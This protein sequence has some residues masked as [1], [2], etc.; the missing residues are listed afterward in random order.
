MVNSNNPLYSVY[1]WTNIQQCMLVVDNFHVKI[2]YTYT[3][4]FI[5]GQLT[6]THVCCIEYTWLFANAQ[7]Y[8]VL[9]ISNSKCIF[10]TFKQFDSTKPT[11]HLKNIYT[12]FSFA[13]CDLETYEENYTHE[14]DFYMKIINNKHTMLYNR[15]TIHSIQRYNALCE[16]TNFF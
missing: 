16:L 4:F 11:Q 6:H 13:Q 2:Q 9:C 3:H 15:P 14:S 5:F 10:L 8:D 1:C 12:F 7:C